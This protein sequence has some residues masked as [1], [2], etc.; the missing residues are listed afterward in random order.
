MLLAGVIHLLAKLG[1]SL[2]V[3]TSLFRAE[4]VVRLVFKLRPKRIYT[5]LPT[6]RYVASKTNTII[7][8]TVVKRFILINWEKRWYGI[9]NNRV[10]KKNK[11]KACSC[12][13]ATEV[14]ILSWFP[15]L[16]EEVCCNGQKNNNNNNL[17]ETVQLI[18]TGQNCFFVFHYF[19]TTFVTWM[20]T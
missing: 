14:K 16:L 11:L 10:A 4:L 3:Y 18:R 1:V 19:P 8:L 7:I 20:K 13:P 5:P 17:M 2:F 15:A 9:V 12:L 6:L